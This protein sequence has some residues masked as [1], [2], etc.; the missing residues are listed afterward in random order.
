MCSDPIRVAI[1]AI[2]SLGHV[3]G[4]T[5]DQIYASTSVTCPNYTLVDIQQALTRGVKRGIFVVKPQTTPVVYCVARNMV[6]LNPANIKY[7]PEG[8][9]GLE[10]YTCYKRVAGPCECLPGPFID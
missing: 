2:I 1:D 6:Q 10:T 3:D 5:A 7:Y 8:L 4:S 9:C